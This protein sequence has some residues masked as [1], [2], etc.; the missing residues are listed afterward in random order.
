MSRKYCLDANFFI[1]AWNKYYS[2]NFCGD[3]WEV[4]DALGKKDIIFVPYEVSNEINKTDDELSKWLKK[5]NINI[6]QVDENVQQCLRDL[7]AFNPS[8]LKLVDNTKNRSLADPWVI[9]HAMKEKAVVVTK[10]YKVTK[11]DS[12]KIKIPNVCE[13]MGIEWINDFQFIEEL[14]IKFFCKIV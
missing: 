3:Y 1:E 8:H 9:A 13:N 2:P 11:T 4:L 6:Y 5:S 14:R 7:F 10:E 12:N